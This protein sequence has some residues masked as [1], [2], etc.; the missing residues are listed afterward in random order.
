M[1]GEMDILSRS[2]IFGSR[3]RSRN[4][5]SSCCENS[6]RDSPSAVRASNPCRTPSTCRYGVRMATFLSSERPPCW[7]RIDMMPVTV[8]RSPGLARSTSRRSTVSITERGISPVGTISGD[9]CSFHVCWSTYL[10]FSGRM[11]YGSSGHGCSF[12]CRG[13][14]QTRGIAAPAKPARTGSFLTFWQLE[15]CAKISVPFALTLDDAMTMPGIVTTCATVDASISRIVIGCLEEVRVTWICSRS[16]SAV[17]W[18]VRDVRIAASI[19]AFSKS[20]R[21]RPGRRSSSVPSFASH[22][23]RWS[24]STSTTYCLSPIAERSSER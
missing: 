8:T 20:G 2:R 21:C 5:S 13:R 24:M 18:S 23:M 12:G 6:E 22:I 9:S 11:T 19:A 17:S 16:V 3:A 7:E 10:H 1:A 14:S 4:S 15:H